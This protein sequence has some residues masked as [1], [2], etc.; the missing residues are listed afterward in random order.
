MELR[1]NVIRQV[2]FSMGVAFYPEE[3]AQYHILESLADNRMYED[4]RM[5][6][7]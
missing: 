3:S 5:R 6:K 1:E 7:A 2:E 4:K